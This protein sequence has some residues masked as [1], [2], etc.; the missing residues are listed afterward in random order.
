MQTNIFPANRITLNEIHGY[1]IHTS[2]HV[3]RGD[4]RGIAT[5]KMIIIW[6]E[7]FALDYV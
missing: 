3:L 1:V 7:C 6:I 5:E 4:T 2:T